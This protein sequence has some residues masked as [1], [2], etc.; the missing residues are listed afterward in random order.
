VLSSLKRLAVMALLLGA[1]GCGTYEGTTVVAYSPSDAMEPPPTAGLSPVQC[2]FAN[3][4][5]GA[6]IQTCLEGAAASCNDAGRLLE[7]HA[8]SA[9]G[10]TEAYEYF[11]RACVIGH[12]KACKNAVRVAKRRAAALRTVAP[13]THEDVS[14]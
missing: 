9:N 2:S 13:A 4:T 8:T 6:C 12:P 3:R 1:P 7:L 10:L 5:Q 14:F 11:E